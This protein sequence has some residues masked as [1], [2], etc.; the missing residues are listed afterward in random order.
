MRIALMTLGSLG[1]VSPFVAL[2]LGLQAAGHDIVLV[3][4]ANF[5]TFIRSRGLDFSSVGINSQQVLENKAGQS[6][7]ATGNNPLLFFRYFSRLAVPLMRQA[8]IDCWRACQGDKAV[9]AIVAS[10]LALGIGFS[11]AEKLGVPSFLASPCP[12]ASTR[13]FASPYFPAAPAWLSFG[14]GYYN[15]LTSTLCLQAFWQLIRPSIN[16]ALRE[17]LDMPPLPS[18]WLLNQVRTRRMKVLYSY[19]PSITPPPPDWG[20]WNHVTGFWLVER[21]ADWQPPADLVDFLSSGPAPV[22]IGF[23]SM[24]DRNPEE[25]TEIALKAL[26]LSKQR[27]IL[28]TGWGGLSNADLPD[29]V[30]KLTSAPH[31]WLF[32]Q[33]AAVVHHGGPGTLAAGL[34]AGIPTV[35]TPFFADHFFWGRRIF[36]LGVGPEPI[37][38]KRLSAERLAAAISIATGDEGLRA[39]TAALGARMRAEDGVARAVGVLE[40]YLGV[41]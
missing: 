26:A 23:G 41:G 38:H 10:P 11:I 31:D 9:E 5:E 21:Q 18:Q 20:D 29:E 13:A 39:R 34:R 17:V 36:E 35:I 40:G 37:P 6:W 8:M 4:H 16:N 12:L 27:G 14:S 15:Q 1:D 3:T 7:L 32:P 24:T 19:S 22:Y 33:M 28:L 30:F 25:A 2:G